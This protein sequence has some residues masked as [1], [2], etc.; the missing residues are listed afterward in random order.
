MRA[1]ILAALILTAGAVHA[2]DI[3]VD[4][5][6]ITVPSAAL[7]DVAA[8]LAGEV[9]TTTTVE[10]VE[11]VDPDDGHIY[12][13]TVRSFVVVPETPKVKLAR[14]MRGAGIRA[15]RQAIKSMRDERAQAAAQADADALP[16][17]VSDEE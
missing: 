2:A 8:W 11:M 10:Y 9:L 6:S 4:L 12:T 16:N 5:G 17:P 7:A 13:N 3:V 14:I 15:V 1:L